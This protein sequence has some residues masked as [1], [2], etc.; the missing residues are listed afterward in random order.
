VSRCAVCSNYTFKGLEPPYVRAGLGR[1]ALGPQWQFPNPYC[2]RI[3]AT[4]K[5]VPEAE[6]PARE[7]FLEGTDGRCN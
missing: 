4:F 2:E 3:C 7:K 6:M 5:Q 1:C